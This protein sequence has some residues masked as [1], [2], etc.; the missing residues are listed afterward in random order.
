[1]LSGNTAL[2]SFKQEYSKEA[3]M[4]YYHLVENFHNSNHSIRKVETKLWFLYFYY[5][6]ILT[7]K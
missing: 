2:N 7:F 5:V 4:V 6:K 1:M 3:R